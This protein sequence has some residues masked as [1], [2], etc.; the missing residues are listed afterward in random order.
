M[1]LDLKRS[2]TPKVI[3]DFLMTLLVKVLAGAEREEII[4]MIKAFK[5][6]F[7]E[8]PAWE[9]GSPKRVNNSDHVWQERRT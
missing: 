7:K 3:Q 8:R 6:D 4:E 5:Y 9:K 2:D 1:G